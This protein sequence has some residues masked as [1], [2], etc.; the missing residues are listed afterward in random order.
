MP[1]QQIGDDGPGWVQFPGFWGEA[2]Y[3][4]APAPIGTV[5]FGTAPVGP[6][7][8]AEWTDPLGTLATW[9]TG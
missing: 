2:Q 6:A 5:P 3:F 9:P 4:H 1:V 8:H 7:F